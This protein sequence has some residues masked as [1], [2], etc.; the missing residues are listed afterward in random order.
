MGGISRSLFSS[1]RTVIGAL[2]LWLAFVPAA[3]SDE[4]MRVTVVVARP[5]DIIERAPVVGSLIAREEIEVHPL[6]Q[7]RAIEHILVEIGQ[8]VEKGQPL[9]VLDTT[10]AVMLLGKNEVSLLRARA[11]VEVE[12]SKLEV[13]AVTEA[14]TR[15]NLERSRALQPKGAV[16]Q[17]VLDQHQNTHARAL[18]ELGVA[19]QSLQLAEADAELIVRER[20]EIELTIE[21]STVKA[22]DAGLVLKRSARIGAMTSSS[23]S[24]LFVIAKN[25]AIEFVAQVTETSFMQL[26]EGMR[27]EISLSGHDRPLSGTLRLN[28]AELDP[29]T[30]SGEVRIELDETA[31]LKPGAFARGSIYASARR[32]ILLPGSAVKTASGASTVLVVKEGVVDVRPV[33]V[34]ARQDGLVEIVDGVSDGE[35]VVLKSGSFLKAD[36]KVRPVIATSVQPSASNL[37]AALPTSE[38][39]GAI[40]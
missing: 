36:E 4:Q 35:M 13:A 5:D 16:S 21:R 22:P 29:T 24:P 15:K 17:Q 32:N 28:A 30:R 2:S 20:R 14:E 26:E 39:T 31:G 7:A 3:Q 11:A 10:E 12:A 25:A 18:A 8:R 6:V 27:A 9:A 38:T 23:A 1:L 40:Q 34:G 19:R 37:A 33:T